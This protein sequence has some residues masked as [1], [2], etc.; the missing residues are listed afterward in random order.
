MFYLLSVACEDSCVQRHGF[1]TVTD[2]TVRTYTVARFVLLFHTTTL[3]LSKSLLSAAGRY[4][5]HS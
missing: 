5:K 4:L 2:L 1:V 3:I